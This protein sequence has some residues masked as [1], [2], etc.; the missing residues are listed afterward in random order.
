M[1]GELLSII[2]YLM[3]VTVVVLHVELLLSLGVASSI[4]FFCVA[5]QS[6]LFSVYLTT[7]KVVATLCPTLL[8]HLHEG[9][10]TF[11][12]NLLVL[13]KSQVLESDS[14]RP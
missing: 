10:S 4:S 12:L 9:E 13:Q 6:G 5:P 7:A 2:A 1:T 11:E 14:S 8:G 3:S